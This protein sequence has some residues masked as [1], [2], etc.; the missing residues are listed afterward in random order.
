MVPE[1]FFD[2][3]LQTNHFYNVHCQK[4]LHFRA[5]I[6]FSSIPFSHLHIIRM[7]QTQ[8]KI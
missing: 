5:E 1:Y 8:R 3:I 2:L 7:K 6:M 4:M